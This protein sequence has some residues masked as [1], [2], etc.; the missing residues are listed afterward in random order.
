MRKNVRKEDKRMKVGIVTIVDY[1][2]YGNRLQNYALQEV[3][4]SLDTDV[5]T[6]VNIP[7]NSQKNLPLLSRY[8]NRIIELGISGNVDRIKEKLKGEPKEKLLKKKKQAFREFTNEWIDETDFKVDPLNIPENLGELYDYFVTGSDQV[9]NPN[10]RN[11]SAFDFLTFA[12]KRKRIAYAP[13]FGVSNIPD[14]Y[15]EKY[16]KWL[17]EMNALSVRED[18]GAALINRLTGRDVPVHVDPTVLLT[19]EKWETFAKQSSVRPEKKYLLTYYLGK[20]SNDK[21]QLIDDLAIEN[22]LEIV[23]LSSYRDEK[24]YDIRP[25]EFVDMIQ[26][27][28]IFLTDSFHGAVFSI[29]LETPFVIFNRVSKVPSMN[30][31]IDTLLDKFQLSNRKYGFLEKE[32][33]FD[34]DFSHVPNILE[35]ERIK[36]LTYLRQALSIKEAK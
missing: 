11:G 28:D 33:L 27:A 13:S 19:K 5:E 36:S 30:S 15:K 29:L 34:I 7:Y 12:P 32:E 16:T 1:K 4:K 25:D 17:S 26:H 24:Y 21:K 14:A 10:Y 3:L 8:W 20:I 35:E 2:N 6:I 18:A 31:R 22:D 23:N 9:W